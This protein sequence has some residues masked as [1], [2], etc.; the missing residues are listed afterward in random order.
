[1]YINVFG[2]YDRPSLAYNAVHHALEGLPKE[3]LTLLYTAEAAD[4]FVNLPV[5]L[6]EGEAA[7]ENPLEEVETAYWQKLPQLVRCVQVDQLDGS[8][9]EDLK[10]ICHMFKTSLDAKRLVLVTRQ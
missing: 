5:P 3:K 4:L 7:P 1:M 10:D 9:K 2:S 8:E 6:A